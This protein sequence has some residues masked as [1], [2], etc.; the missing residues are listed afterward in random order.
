V[1]TGGEA[2]SDRGKGRRR[3]S[4]L[5]GLSPSP[6]KIT[7][8]HSLVRLRDELFKGA[9]GGGRGRGLSGAKGEI[10]VERENQRISF[11]PPITSGGPSRVIEAVR[12]GRVGGGKLAKRTRCVV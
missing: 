11:S 4:E 5:G 7:S 8:L 9:E 3:N 10:S 12:R 1:K 6:S 2:T